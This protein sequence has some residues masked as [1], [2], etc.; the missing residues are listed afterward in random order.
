MDAVALERTK[1]K[2]VV[3]VNGVE[4]NNLGVVEGIRRK[5]YL[6]LGRPT[7]STAI[8]D[9]L[10]TTPLTSGLDA[11]VLGLVKELP[12]RVVVGNHVPHSERVMKCQ[13]RFAFSSLPE[14]LNVGEGAGKE[15]R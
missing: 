1:P 4:S 3:S 13:T 8:G 6:D 12:L 11:D 9:V 15:M 7:L 2:L 5:L 10:T 14:L